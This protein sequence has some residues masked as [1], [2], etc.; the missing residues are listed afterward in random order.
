MKTYDNIKDSL[1]AL[2]RSKKMAD[3]LNKMSAIFLSNNAETFEDMMTAGMGVI[4]NA[5]DFDRLNV[6]QNI[7]ANEGLYASQIYR[8]DR[9]A[10][11][12]TDITPEFAYVSYSKL[13]PRWEE[14]FLNGES[15]NSPANLLPEK[16]LFAAFGALSAFVTP[17]FIKGEFWGF[18]LFSDH[19]NERFFDDDCAEMLKS[20]AFL[21]ANAV[22]RADMEQEIN[23]VHKLN[24]TVLEFAPFGLTI[25]DENVTI[26][27]CNDEILKMCGTT[28]QYYKNNF[29]KFSPEYQADGQKS[30]DKALEIIKHAKI[31]ETN[32][33]EW[34]HQNINGEIIP[35]ELT[36]T[37][38]MQVGKFTGFA[39]A[40]DLR[41]IKKMEKEIAKAGKINQSILENL[42][43]G[44][45]MFNGNPPRV[46]D[47][48]EKLEKM[49]NATKKDIIDRYFED[50]SPEYLP[51]GRPLLDEATSVGIRAMN[52]E[53]IKMKWP[54]KTKEGVPVP[55]DVTLM[56]VEDEDGYTGLGFL[57]DL[58]DINKREMELTRTYKL[59]ELQL[60][61]LNT[62]VKASKIGLW[63][64]E[65]IRDD[66]VNNR[67]II[68]WSDEFRKI[69]GFTDEN[70]FPNVICSFHN[71][72]HPDDFERVTTAVT[73]HMLDTTGQTPYDI[74]YRV[75]RKNGELAYIHATGETIRD[76]NGNAIRVAGAV[77][78]I[79]EAKN[80]LINT[81]KLRVEAE[82]ASMA[83]SNFLSNMSHEIRTPMNAIIGM[84]VIGKSADDVPRK[85]YC[86]EKIENASQHLLGVIN[87][88][89]DMSKIEANKFELSNEEFDFEKM[90]QRVVNIVAFRAEEKR[91]KFTVHIDKSIPRNLIGDDQRLAQVITNLLSN[92]VKFTPEEGSVKLDTRFLG[93]K[94]DVYTIQVTIT[95]SGIGISQ[96]QRKQLFQSFQQAD[97]KTSRKFGGTGLGL[98][99]SKNIVELMGGSIELRSEID[100]GSTFSFVFDAKRGTKKAPGLSE[101]G[102]DWGNVSIMAVDDDQE[103]LDYFKEILQGFGKNCDTALSGQEALALIGKNGMYDIFFVDWK[104]PG[105]DGIMLARELKAKSKSPEHTIVIMIS[106]AEWSAIADKAKKAGVDKFLSKPLFP[107]AI[108]DVIT[109]VIGSHH[110]TIEKPADNE[111]IF[112]GYR[113]LL[114]EDV[115]INRE[116]VE[117]LVQPTLL[118]VD[119]AENGREAVAMFEKSPNKYDLIL[120]DVQMPGMDGYEATRRIREFEKVLEDK[121]LYPYRQIPII[122][123]TANVFREDVEKCIAAGMNDHIGKPLNIDEFFRALHKY[124]PGMET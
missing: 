81:E 105:M 22:I 76:E 26:I 34:L 52:G 58:T 75:I 100:K 23:K 103:I 86:F 43:I 21:C 68:T 54:H 119:C 46:Y 82:A 5:A 113:V 33:A 99:I 77:M 16:Q 24:Q 19:H 37:C 118:E 14:L 116:I 67:N 25:F 104:M 8:W 122:A 91:Q 94:D 84:T 6:W 102:I 42:P 18:L 65:V 55:C 108:A 48:N 70:D 11:G 32:S 114:A 12:T 17:V 124:L 10:G 50:Y 123:M 53:T 120:M 98:V 30:T 61:K 66:P 106:A 9:E 36:V 51:D 74:E 15:I 111:K 39:F 69:F 44:M 107:S 41:N 62:V 117:T 31:G 59:N 92:A 45:I 28:K 40:Y 56:R 110:L 93:R 95:D 47:C 90:L 27:D 112:K 79:T 72:L 7:S 3:A 80:T 83:K 49:F 85:D 29:F 4:A 89:L 2:E 13:V 64:M 38:I 115:E 63:D 97:S 73:K 78:D 88:I 35:C 60:A 109:E 20:A 96:E 71:C 87:D 1:E 101:I 121:S 57:Y